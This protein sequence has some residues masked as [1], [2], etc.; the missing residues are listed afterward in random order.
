M[1][2]NASTEAWEP[3]TDAADRD[4]AKAVP[5]GDG[6]RKR[7]GAAEPT[8]ERAMAATTAVTT[9]ATTA[10]NP[11]VYL[12]GALSPPSLKRSSTAF[13]TSV[14][15]L[16]AVANAQRKLQRLLQALET[17]QALPPPPSEKN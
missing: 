10:R 7:R 17:L 3:A 15:H 8:P 13:Q 12:F 5:D 6:L 9:A 2:S 11:A 16:V 14:Q 1:Y 4:A